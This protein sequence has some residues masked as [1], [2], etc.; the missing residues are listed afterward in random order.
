MIDSKVTKRFAENLPL[1]RKAVGWTAEELGNKVDVKRQTIMSIEKK[2]QITVPMYLAIRTQLETE[3]ELH[4][5]ENEMVKVALDAFVDN[6]D[7]YGEKDKEEIKKEITLL[8]PALRVNENERKDVSNKWKA[9]IALS[10][11]AAVLSTIASIAIGAWR[12]K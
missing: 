9:L 7:K 12:K 10:V 4:P 2:E 3:I 1:I 5:E 6:P 8:S 11:S